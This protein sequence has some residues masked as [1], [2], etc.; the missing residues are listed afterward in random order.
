MQKS[1]PDFISE[2]DLFIKK[3]YY[4]FTTFLVR[5]PSLELMFTK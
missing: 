1:R 2:R 4:C 5:L 3:I